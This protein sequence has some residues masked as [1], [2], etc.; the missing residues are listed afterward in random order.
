MMLKGKRI[1]ITG[2]CSGIGKASAEKCIKEGASVTIMDFASE[3]KLKEVEQELGEHCFTVRGDATK[4]E[5]INR[6]VAYAVEKMGG[7]DGA[8]NNVGGSKP[9]KIEEISE[10]DF[11]DC[12][13]ISLYSTFYSIRAEVKEIEKNSGG[14]IVNISSINSA[15][16]SSAAVAYNCA[17]AGVDILT[18]TAALE[19][20]EKNIRVNAI[21]PG[22]I[23]T[24]GVQKVKALPG[25]EDIIIEWTPLGRFGKPEEVAN[26][27]AFMLSDECAYMTGCV[28]KLDGGIEEFGNPNTKIQ[29]TVDFSKL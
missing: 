17:K 13:R 8:L 9:G 25:Y 15:L 3:E 26:M 29:E 28:I 5:E 11:E 22:A 20:G 14:S 19:F 12:L 6:C 4:S 18:R 24:E 27:V 23:D 1:F 16:P 2:G 7:L 21:R 10:K